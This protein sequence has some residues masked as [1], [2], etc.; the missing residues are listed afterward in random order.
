MDY[1]PDYQDGSDIAKA[2]KYIRSKFMQAN[3]SRLT[4]YAQ[5][6]WSL[7]LFPLYSRLFFVV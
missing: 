3:R 4:I 7:L 6:I 5:Y 1:F 2:V